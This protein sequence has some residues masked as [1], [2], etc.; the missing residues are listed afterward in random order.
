[1]GLPEV[2]S[3]PPVSAVPQHLRKEP[4]T[5]GDAS[6]AGPCAFNYHAQ[7][8]RAFGVRCSSDDGLVHQFILRGEY[9]AGYS[10]FMACSCAATHGGG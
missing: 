5:S 8:V 7:R 9:G 1:M 3:D 6:Q 2:G 4:S 10:P